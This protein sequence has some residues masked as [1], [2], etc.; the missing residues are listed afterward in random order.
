MKTQIAVFILSISLGANILLQA[1]TMVMVDHIEMRPTQE[2]QFDNNPIEVYSD[3]QTVTARKERKS[4]RVTKP[5][6]HLEF[7]KQNANLKVQVS[8]GVDNIEIKLLN[9]NQEEVYKEIVSNNDEVSFKEINAG[10]Y[11]LN[12]ETELISES[13][14]IYIK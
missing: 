5:S 14:L 7:N 4:K 6:L 11:L 3:A 2:L 8:E 9:V 1:Q 12:I 10:I 13:K